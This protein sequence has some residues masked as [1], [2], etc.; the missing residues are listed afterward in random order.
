[1]PLDPLKTSPHPDPLP[2]LNFP[3]HILNDILILDRLAR[4]RF[5]SVAP[6]VLIPRRYAVDGVFAIGYDDDV[7]VS[8]KDFQGAGDGG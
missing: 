8:W 5:P 1:M 7:P 6:P 2:L 4:S 3:H